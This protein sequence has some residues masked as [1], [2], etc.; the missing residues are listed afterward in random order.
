MMQNGRR[1]DRIADDFG[2]ERPH[3]HLPL[4]PNV[5]AAD[6]ITGSVLR[7]YGGLIWQRLKIF[8]G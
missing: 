7:V 8:Q 5:P 6:L 1:M 2:G 3:Q 4:C